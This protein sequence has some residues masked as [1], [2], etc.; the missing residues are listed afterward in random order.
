MTICFSLMEPRPVNGQRNAPIDG[1]SVET[2]ASI[3]AGRSAVAGNLLR[4]KG[5]KAGEP[6]LFRVS[7]L[8]WLTRAVIQYDMFP[9]RSDQRVP[10]YNNPKC[11]IMCCKFAYKLARMLTDQ[12]LPSIR[13]T[14]ATLAI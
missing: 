4:G 11:G 14:P 5:V 1:W 12:R 6:N 13:P 10:D 2:G 8:A 9:V 7:T 3:P